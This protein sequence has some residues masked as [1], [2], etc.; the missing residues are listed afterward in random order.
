MG[1]GIGMAK[2][3]HA[4]RG[5][6]LIE[7]MISMVI[8]SFLVLGLAVMAGNMQG[9]YTIQSNYSAIHDK[10]RFASALFSAVIQ[11]AGNYT[12]VITQPSGAL[13]DVTAVLPAYA[14]SGSGAPF[15]AG[16]FLWGTTANSSDSINVRYYSGTN[17]AG[18]PDP[19][20]TTCLGSSSTTG[21]YESVLS[22]DTVNNN[23]ICQVG[24]NGAAPASAPTGATAGSSVIL[25]DGVTSMQITYGV[26]EAPNQFAYV[27]TPNMTLNPALWKLS[28][29]NTFYAS[30]LK[31]VTVT[32]TFS[33]VNNDAAQTFTETFPVMYGAP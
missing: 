9:S 30:Q 33:K 4:E 21:V 27:S 32:L 6:G 15:S 28:G 29:P 7:L 13:T 10:E 31:S 16:Q 5:F 24:L 22:V 23:L 2:Q 20:G 11:S 17:V 18:N 19:D 12:S 1:M 8:A 14:G 25:I 3:P 26:L